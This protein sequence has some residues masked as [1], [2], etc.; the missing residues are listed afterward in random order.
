EFQQPKLES[1]GPK[2][3][4]IESKNAS[5]N[6]PNELKESTEVNESSNVPLVKKLVSDDKL[7]KKTVVS[8][9]AKI[10]FIKAKQQK[11]QLGNQLK[12]FQQPKLE[13]YGPK[14]CKIESKNA[15]ENIPNELKESTKVKESSN[16]PLVKKLVSDDKL[17]K[18]TVVS[19]DAKIEFIK[20]K[21][22]K[23]QLGNQLSMLGCTG[24]KVLGETKE[25]NRSKNLRT[26]LK[27][28]NSTHERKRK[29]SRRSSVNSGD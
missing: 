5:E 10:E 12:E 11:N 13:S 1:Y 24:H 25:I 15:S 21:Q 16:V 20:A 22:Q 9:D 23:N 14:S 27:S 2:S 6:I 4:K 19:T 7:E 17:E 8:T 3:C 28:S 29:N 18:K 26:S